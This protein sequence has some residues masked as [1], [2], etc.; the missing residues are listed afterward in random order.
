M[1]S[2]PENSVSLSSVLGH[3]GVAELDKVISDW[4][5]EDSWHWGAILDSVGVAGIDAHSWTGS[6]LLVCDSY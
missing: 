6:H 2:M 1:S 5:S 4:S 3:V